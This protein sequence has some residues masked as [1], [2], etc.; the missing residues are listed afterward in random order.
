MNDTN[1]IIERLG[2]VFVESLRVEVPSPDTDL[3]ET[4]ILDSFQFVELLLQLERRFA[5]RIAIE[6]IN[7]DDLRTLKRIA[8]LVAA[9][10]APADPPAARASLGA[11]EAERATE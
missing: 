5:F 1:S 2:A 9:N 7:L 6:N 4:G 10:G 11:A 8:R 3:L